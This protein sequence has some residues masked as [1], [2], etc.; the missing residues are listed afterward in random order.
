MSTPSWRRWWKT[1]GETE[2][3]TL[4]EEEWDPIGVKDEPL[5]AGEYDSYLLPL[6]RRLREGASREEVAEFLDD[7]EAELGCG[8]GPR[9]AAVAER[10]FRWYADSTR[11]PPR[12]S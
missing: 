6:A 3:R 4:L 12:P 1:R 11:E 5:A 9:D 10:V 8:G 7:A 2:L